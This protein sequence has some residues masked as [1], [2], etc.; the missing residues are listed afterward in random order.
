[1]RCCCCCRDRSADGFGI[2][3]VC[4]FSIPP[5]I[6]PSSSDALPPGHVDLNCFVTDRANAVVFLEPCYSLVTA[7]LHP[8][9]TVY[10]RHAVLA[11]LR[12]QALFL[13]LNLA[14]RSV[15]WCFGAV[16]NMFKFGSGRF[17]RLRAFMFQ[18]Q[19]AVR[20]PP[21]RTSRRQHATTA[22][23]AIRAT[24]T[25]KNTPEQRQQQRQQQPRRH[26]SGLCI[27]R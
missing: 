21:P 20:L 17:L 11:K 4:V 26:A 1:M 8:C 9:C 16:D 18:F 15:A 2:A 24:P 3:A 7:L 10:R 22:A 14:A 6:P 5:C 23:R 19:T 12:G 27:Q 13:L 25:M